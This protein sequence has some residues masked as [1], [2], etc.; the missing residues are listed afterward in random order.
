MFI[1]FY[2][3]FVFF[4]FFCGCPHLHIANFSSQCSEPEAYLRKGSCQQLTVG[5]NSGALQWH[6]ISILL[7]PKQISVVSK[8]EKKRKKRK[9]IPFKW[10]PA[11][12]ILGG[13]SAAAES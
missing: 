2:Y 5:P 10:D 9:A 12:I 7:D 11:N 6:K 13:L 8:S 4:F 3:S 1:F